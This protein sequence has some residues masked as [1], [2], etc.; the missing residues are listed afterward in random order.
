MLAPVL[1]TVA[2]GSLMQKHLKANGTSNQLIEHI[3]NARLVGK[4]MAHRI[5]ACGPGVVGKIA[6]AFDPC[7]NR[8]FGMEYICMFHALYPSWKAQW[9]S[10]W[11]DAR[12]EITMDHQDVHTRLGLGVKI[13]A[14]PRGEPM[15]LHVKKDHTVIGMVT[16]EGNFVFGKF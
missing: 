16:A 2:M 10:H 3:E 9:H 14:T 11:S 15:V 6:R 12:G 1:L 7:K 4:S 13:L 8:A 5:T